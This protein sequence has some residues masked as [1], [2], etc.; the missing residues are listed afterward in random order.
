MQRLKWFG[1]NSFY[2]IYMFGYPIPVL[3]FGNID[4][5]YRCESHFSCSAKHIKINFYFVRE[6]V[7]RKDLDIQFI[8]IVDQVADV[9]TKGLS[10]PQ[11]LVIHSQLNITFTKFSIGGRIKDNHQ[12]KSHI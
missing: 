12:Q 6:K 10:P 5:R 2:V 4:A 7:A 1:F 8:S 9:M 3:W 11:F